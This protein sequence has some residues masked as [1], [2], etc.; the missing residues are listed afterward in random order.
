MSILQITLFTRF[1]LNSYDLVSSHQYIV[2]KT[3]AWKVVVNMHS[4]KVCYKNFV[5]KGINQCCLGSSIILMVVGTLKKN[6]VTSLHACPT[7]SLIK[8]PGRKQYQ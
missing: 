8:A 3:L 2:R 7:Q 1:D 4:F 5:L 6:I